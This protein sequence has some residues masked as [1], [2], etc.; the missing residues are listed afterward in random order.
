MPHND[1]LVV[2][3]RVRDFDVK[4][5]LIDQGS[6]IEIMYYDAFKQLKLRDTDLA[7]STSPLVGFNSQPEWPLG[8]I[9]LPVKAGSVVKQVEFWVLKVLSTY[10]LILGRRWLHAIKA[11][12]LTYHQVMRFPSAMEEVEEI[13]GDQVMS[14]QCF[15][16]VN[17]SRATKGFVQMI[18]GPED[19]SVLDYVG[20]KAKDQAV[21]ELMEVRIDAKSPNKFFLL[22]SSL[23]AQE[24]TE[25]VEFL[26]VNIEVFAWTSY[27]MPGVDPSFIC[28]QLNVFP[29]ARPVIQRTRRSALHHAK[30]I[31]KEVRNLLEA[32]VIQEVHYPWWVSNTVVVPKKNEKWRVCVDY[33]TVN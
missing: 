26:M 12:A 1:A 29:D 28:H 5:I 18:E 33:K 8:K 2:T 10:N 27:D 21:E 7:P 15:V 23:T 24:R 4:C 22:R 17:G 25:M 20:A 32:R 11:V 30:V 3:L 9:I 16:A 6:S 14:K 13:W 31:T 19:Q